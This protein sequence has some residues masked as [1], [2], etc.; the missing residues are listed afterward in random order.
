[1]V[2]SLVLQLRR[3]RAAIRGF[4]DG[5]FGLR[6]EEREDQQVIVITTMAE[7]PAKH[8]YLIDAGLIG[9][10]VAAIF[11]APYANTP[12]LPWGL[13]SGAA[14]LLRGRGVDL[15]GIWAQFTWLHD[16]FHR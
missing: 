10:L 13:A 1:M 15:G 11:Y 14:G 7:P 12:W 6:K 2:E 9:I 8:S 16:N 4:I 5:L 3:L